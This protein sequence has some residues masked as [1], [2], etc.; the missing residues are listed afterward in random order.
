MQHHIISVK[1]RV[2]SIVGDVVASFPD[3]QPRL[4]FVG[5]RDYDD[6]PP[7]TT[8]DFTASPE[9]FR[10]FLAKVKAS[11]GA[12]PAEDV[13]SGLQ[14]AAGLSWQSE[15]RIIVHI[16]GEMWPGLLLCLVLLGLPMC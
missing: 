14:A 16:A 5:Y 1:E 9:Q 10:A 3:A 4:A 2:L 15:N 12:D 6:K 13:F 11:G 8:L 7:L